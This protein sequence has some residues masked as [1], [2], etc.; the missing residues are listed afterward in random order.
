[1]S[2]TDYDDEHAV[3][4]SSLDA[5]SDS[6]LPVK[7]KKRKTSGSAI[8]TVTK[9]A[10]AKAKAKTAAVATPPNP[11]KVMR[12]LPDDDHWPWP[13][14]PYEINGPLWKINWRWKRRVELYEHFNCVYPNH[15]HPNPFPEITFP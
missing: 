1:M 15:R 13:L 5:S 11:A 6:D 10:T 2:A 14:Y 9:K 4:G 12:I 8:M 3:G 7:S